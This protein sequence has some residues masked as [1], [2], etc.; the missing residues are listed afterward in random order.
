M[1]VIEF[2][3]RKQQ[4]ARVLNILMIVIGRLLNCVDVRAKIVEVEFVYTR[5]EIRF[6]GSD[7]GSGFCDAFASI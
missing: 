3:A 1:H 2:A 4:N 5:V 7:C 6:Y